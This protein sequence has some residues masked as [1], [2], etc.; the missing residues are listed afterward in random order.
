MVEFIFQ[1]CGDVESSQNSFTCKATGF[2]YSR[3]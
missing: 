3:E 2:K 1:K